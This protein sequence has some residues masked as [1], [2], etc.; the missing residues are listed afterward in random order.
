MLSLTWLAHYCLSYMMTIS[1]LGRIRFLPLA[2]QIKDDGILYVES[3]GDS[4]EVARVHQDMPKGIEI[5]VS[6]TKGRS[7][8]TYHLRLRFNDEGPPP[9]LPIFQGLLGRALENAEEKVEV[10]GKA[11]EGTKGEEKPNERQETVMERI[12]S[13]P[14]S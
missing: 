4:C 11:Q 7:P 12:Q 13:S 10:K 3:P 2:I 5:V 14:T 6:P 9:F 1:C 8:V